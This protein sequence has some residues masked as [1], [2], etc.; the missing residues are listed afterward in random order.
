MESDKGWASA[1]TSGK[2][3]KEKASG[4]LHPESE[5]DKEVPTGSRPRGTSVLPC[6]HL[7]A[8]P[9][10]RD[11]MLLGS[12]RKGGAGRR[13]S[14]GGR[15]AGWTW[16]PRGGQRTCPTYLRGRPWVMAPPMER[17]DREPR[18]ER[19]RERRG[20][21]ETEIK[22]GRGRQGPRGTGPLGTSPLGRGLNMSEEVH[23]DTQWGGTEGGAGQEGG[24]EGVGPEGG[25]GGGQK[26]REGGTCGLHCPW[27]R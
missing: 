6:N 4:K 2:P 12:W 10:S 27:G 22:R 14:G 3:K 17:D 20:D 21:I 25:G 1:S 15:Q 13:W 11:V 23:Q 16:T 9:P 19:S 5:E 26:R 7:M 18:K 24:C 8:L